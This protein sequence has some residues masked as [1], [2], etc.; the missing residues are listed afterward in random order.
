[1]PC[2]IH[3]LTLTR[4]YRVNILIVSVVLHLAGADTS[5]EMRH[6]KLQAGI[7]RVLL[8]TGS[9]HFPKRILTHVPSPCLL[10][11]LYWEALH[12]ANVYIHLHALTFLWLQ[13]KLQ[14]EKLSRLLLYPSW[15]LLLCFIV[16]HITV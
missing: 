3:F 8:I 4:K 11:L 16:T 2:L 12:T 7:Q 15:L 1:M 5:V 13:T 9:L 10:A 14:R 6:V